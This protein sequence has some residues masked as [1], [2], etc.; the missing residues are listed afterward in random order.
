[1]GIVTTISLRYIEETFP[2]L[3]PSGENF[4]TASPKIFKL[5]ENI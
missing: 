4:L 1:M 5:F 3:A 2:D